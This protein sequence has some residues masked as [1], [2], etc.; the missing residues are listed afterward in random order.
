MVPTRRD[1]FEINVRYGDS[2]RSCTEHKTREYSTNQTPSA[3]ETY[4]AGLRGL[5][6]LDAA[7]IADGHRDCQLC[8]LIKLIASNVTTSIT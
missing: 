1:I 7:N 5:L 6:D 8:K 3:P 2:A 4:K